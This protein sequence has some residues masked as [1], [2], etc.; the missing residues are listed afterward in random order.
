[1]RYTYRKKHL[2]EIESI[3]KKYDFE[4]L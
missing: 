4:D 1:F 2:K 3:G